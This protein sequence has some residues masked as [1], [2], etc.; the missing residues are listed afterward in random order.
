MFR[1]E[2]V[3]DAVSTFSYGEDTW[4]VHCHKLLFLRWVITTFRD[5]RR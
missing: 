3:M 4:D 5:G 2:R 1:G